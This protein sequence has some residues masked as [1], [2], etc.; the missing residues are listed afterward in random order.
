MSA[1]LGYSIRQ[2]KSRSVRAGLLFPVGRIHRLCR[3]EVPGFSRMG[4]FAPVYLTAV[5]EYLTAEVLEQAGIIS[6]MLQYDR[7]T[8]QH[9]RLAIRE[10]SEL[11]KLVPGTVFAGSGG[12]KMQELCS[13]RTTLELRGLTQEE[14]VTPHKSAKSGGKSSQ[15]KN[16]KK[17]EQEPENYSEDEEDYLKPADS[18]FRRKVRKAPK[19]SKKKKT[20]REVFSLVQDDQHKSVD[21]KEKG[22]SIGKTADRY[23]N[24]FHCN[25]EGQDQNPNEFQEP[26]RTFPEEVTIMSSAGEFSSFNL[27]VSSDGNNNGEARAVKKS[28]VNFERGPVDDGEKRLSLIRGRGGQSKLFFV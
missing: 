27:F 2:K 9:I 4:K 26:R 21:K 18:S 10:D 1:R 7:V 16:R 19:G 13:R 28:A 11:D 3:K 5:L 8:P 12:G 25:Y 22:R 17:K 23:E 24:L 14:D 6:K 20:F 15:G